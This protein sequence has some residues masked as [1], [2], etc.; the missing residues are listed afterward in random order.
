MREKV[1][2]WR[3]VRILS[4]LQGNYVVKVIGVGVQVA[5]KK[6]SSKKAVFADVFNQLLPRRHLRAQL[7]QA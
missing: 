2:E 5:E 7:S 6:K 4:P 3:W 1:T